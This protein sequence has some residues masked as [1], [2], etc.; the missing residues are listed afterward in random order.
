MIFVKT[1]GNTHQ[2]ECFERC[3]AKNSYWTSNKATNCS[4]WTNNKAPIASTSRQGK[5][6]AQSLIKD[7]QSHE[8]EAAAAIVDEIIDEAVPESQISRTKRPII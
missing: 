4:Y 5:I 1:N 6:S 2:E 8:I 7:P 3:C